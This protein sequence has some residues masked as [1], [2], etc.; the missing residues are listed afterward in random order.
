MAST[1]TYAVP[2]NIIISC[3]CAK[4]FVS[5]GLRSLA[6]TS[7]RPLQSQKLQRN[8]FARRHASS[9]K[10]IA[11]QLYYFTAQK[12]STCNPK[13]YRLKLQTLCFF[14]T[15]GNQMQGNLPI[16]H[17]SRLLTVEVAHS[18]ISLNVIPVACALTVP[19]DRSNPGIQIKFSEILAIHTKN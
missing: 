9:R 8:L 2:R 11:T 14:R 3:S 5:D 16:G 17:K 10:V 15:V 6:N 18:V 13:N 12:C 7:Y 4:R 19:A 1:K